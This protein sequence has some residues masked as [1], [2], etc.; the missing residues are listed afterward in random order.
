MY[1]KQQLLHLTMVDTKQLLLCLQVYSESYMIRPK[2]V[3]IAGS[4]LCQSLSNALNN[5]LSK[6]ISPDYT[7]I[8][9][10]SPLY[11]GTANRTDISNFRPVSILK[12]LVDNGIDKYLSPFISVEI[13]DMTIND[14]QLKSANQ[15]NA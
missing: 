7:K 8:A 4:V 10:V 5:S 15:L 14:N 12:T 13:L 2:L 11:K 1:Q 3:K 9:M 6:G